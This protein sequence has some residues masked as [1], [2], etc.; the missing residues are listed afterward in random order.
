[1][2]QW[3]GLSK[4]LYTRGFVIRVL[5]KSIL[6]FLL[7]NLVFAVTT[8]LP[9]LGSLSLYNR[10]LPGR[11]RLP[12]GEN[13]A[14]SYNLSLMSLE[15]M[16][17]S[18]EIA[19]P[20][21]AD[22]FRVLLLGDSATWGILLR[23][24]ETLSGVLNAG[25]YTTE[26]GRRLHFYNIAHPIMALSKDL[27]LLDYAMRCEPDMVIWL[28]TAESFPRQQQ[29]YPPLVQHNAAALRPLIANYDLDIDASDGRLVNFSFWDNTLIGRR[30][31]LADM[32]R[33]QLY[34]FAFAAT[35][36]DQYYPPT[37]TPR[38]NDLP[39][40][41]T[42]YSFTPAHTL[43]SQDLS[44]DVLDAGITRAGNIPVLLVNEP[45][46]IANGENSDIRYNAW[47]PR[48]AYDAYRA[49]IAA[50]AQAGDWLLFDTW[51][52]IAPEHFTDSPVHLDAQ[53][54]RA[55]AAILL[56]LILQ[57]AR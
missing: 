43:T 23:P 17:A 56:P 46:F 2:V 34:G 27:L 5:V 30:R 3:N 4:P 35:G 14:Q 7:A 15:A 21:A 9:L 53:G 42:W 50:P 41:D 45:I 36:I 48:W 31:D 12:Y 38:S 52:A 26:D 18:H 47:Y 10:L 6:L 13:P 39:A 24:E 20:K 16:F 49:L 1:M 37:Y 8:P 29:L 40:D 51:N 44:F 11:A 32:L 55:F 57:N 33:L 54:T 25:G 28:F 19:R 22:E